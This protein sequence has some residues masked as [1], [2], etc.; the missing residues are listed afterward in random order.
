MAKSVLSLYG[1]KLSFSP[2]AAFY[3]KKMREA[4]Y[5]TMIDPFQRKLGDWMGALLVLPAVGGEIFW[6]ASIL[7]A[8]GMLSDTHKQKD[9]L[10][11]IY[12]IMAAPSC[13]PVSMEMKE[14]VCYYC[15]LHSICDH[16]SGAL[17]ICCGIGS[18]CPSLCH[19][20]R[21]DLCRLH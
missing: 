19:G 17:D 1:K 21:S 2:A 14:T 13:F 16:W 20:G 5:T 12:P 18:N 6:S 3:A 9:T 8:L 15:R 11:T 10:L 4:E 7:A